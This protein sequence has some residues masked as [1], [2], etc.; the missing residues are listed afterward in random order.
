MEKSDAK[1]FSL[2]LHIG[3][4]YLTL[5]SFSP[6]TAR[7]PCRSDTPYGTVL[8]HMDLTVTVDGRPT[9][10]RWPYLDPFA[11]LWLA[12]KLCIAFAVMCRDAV[13]DGPGSVIIY[14]DEVTPGNVLRPDSGISK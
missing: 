8:Q 3:P 12:C 1:R 5:Q 6:S 7:P 4:N 14:A 9:P 11:T 2:F 13:R 10:Y